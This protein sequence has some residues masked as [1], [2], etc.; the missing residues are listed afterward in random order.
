MIAAADEERNGRSA[1]E[2]LNQQIRDASRLFVLEPMGGVGEGEKL[3]ARAVAQ[4]F[5]SHFAQEEGVTLS[6]EDA[7][8]N[9]DG[10]ILKFCAGPKESAIPVD[11]A[12]EAAGLR[13]RRAA[14]A[15][16]SEI[17]SLSG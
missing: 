1:A 16:T 7:C 10:L 14:M 8:G 6:P 5:V 2:E 4:T 12:R 13:P 3:G 9:A 17:S 11:H 15:M